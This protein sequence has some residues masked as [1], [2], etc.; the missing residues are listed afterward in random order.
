MV[1]GDFAEG[2]RDMGWRRLGVDERL[3]W[4]LALRYQKPLMRN[5]ICGPNM[6]YVDLVALRESMLLLQREPY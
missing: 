5:T 1:L 4:P 2:K 3:K 6:G